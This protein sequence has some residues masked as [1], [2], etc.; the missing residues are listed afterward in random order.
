MESKKMKTEIEQKYL[1][2]IIK[3]VEQQNKLY[4][5]SKAKELLRKQDTDLF[6]KSS[7][8]LLFYSSPNIDRKIIE[9]EIHSQVS[10]Q[11]KLKASECLEGSPQ[12]RQSS[13]DN[14]CEWEKLER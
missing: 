6:A 10:D 8:N 11:D 2:K 7:L 4:F 13:D 14:N 1:E 5:E 12:E 3:E 9:H